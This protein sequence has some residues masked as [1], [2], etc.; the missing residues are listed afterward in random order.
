MRKRIV[1]ILL[2]LCTLSTI[3]AS[4]LRI[5][6]Q[7]GLDDELYFQLKMEAGILD[8][9]GISVSALKHLDK[10]LSE[11]L[12]G[13]TYSLVT[14]EGQS[15]I[16]V[17]VFGQIQPAFNERE[18]V[19]M[20]DCQR[21]FQ[22]LIL[23]MDIARDL[24]APALLLATLIL[25][26]TTPKERRPSKR[27]LMRAVGLAPLALL[28]PLDAFAIWAAANFNGAFTFFHRLLFTNDLWLLDPRTD[29]LIRIC[30]S[31]MFAQMGLRIAVQA[32]ARTAA[33]VSALLLG[34]QFSSLLS[35]RFEEYMK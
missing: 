31:S 23:V 8:S 15:A 1:C 25:W 27:Q 12:A 33:I 32:L 22:M 20:A 21:L 30:P 16:Q 6:G 24:A 9:A 3:V 18:L 2:F 4:L 10:A 28:V 14:P 7:G 5:V 13:S 35:K 17:E 26:R 29:L 19:H 11:Y 34:I